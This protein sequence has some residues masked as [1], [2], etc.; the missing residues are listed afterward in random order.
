MKV[1]DQRAAYLSG[2]ASHPNTPRH[3]PPT[4][5]LPFLLL[6]LALGVEVWVLECLEGSRSWAEKGSGAGGRFQKRPLGSSD[7]EVAAAS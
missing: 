3:P 5:Q 1:T 2:F 4:H 7:V 6:L